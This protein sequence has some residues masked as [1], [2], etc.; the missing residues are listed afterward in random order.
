LNCAHVRG[1]EAVRRGIK[2]PHQAR[3]R[4]PRTRHVVP[5]VIAIFREEAADC[6]GASYT[7]L[8]K[9]K[10]RDAFGVD[11]VSHCSCNG[12]EPAD[13]WPLTWSAVL[14]LADAD[15]DVRVPD[16]KTTDE[17]LLALWDWVRSHR[18]RPTDA[19]GTVDVE[20]SQLKRQKAEWD[21]PEPW[22][23]YR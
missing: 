20:L 14:A 4:K 3:P 1:V 2:M 13:E 5:T 18:E 9:A 15:S 10:G 22:K 23:L 11:H 12:T 8:T 16:V 6:A 7:R 21:D 17:E 19:D